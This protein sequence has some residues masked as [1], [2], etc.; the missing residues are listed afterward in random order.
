MS[1]TERW[2]LLDTGAAPGPRTAAL[3]E[4]IARA[5]AAGEAPDTLH[6]YNRRPPAVTIGYSLDAEAEVDLDFC[7]RQGIDV[8]RR[9]SGGGAIYTDDRQLVYSLTTKNVLPS[10]VE[11]SL[12]V[13]CT[14]I[15]KA[16]SALGAEAV[17][18]PV[19][20]VLIKGR[21]VSGSAQMR[22]WGVVLQHGT[23]LVDADTEQMFRA[24]RVPRDKKLKHSLDDPQRRV[25]SLKAELGRPPGM[26]EVKAAL[27]LALEETFGVSILPGRLTAREEE[28]VR[29]LVRDRYGNDDWNLRRRKPDEGYRV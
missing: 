20:D 19:N 8:V 5:R 17:F 3:D 29:K 27:R 6:F 2:R 15:A 25:T 24:L 14:A 9:L 7:A 28:M 18:S 13:V 4:A 1:Q 10:A 22:K 11:E 12:R 26:E 16:I 23:V 21:K